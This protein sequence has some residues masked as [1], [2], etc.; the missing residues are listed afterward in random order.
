M[1]RTDYETKVM[2]ALSK[3]LFS[4]MDE[5][6]SENHA[7]INN[8]LIAALYGKSFIA[9]GCI[10]SIILDYE[11]NDYD[12]Y[13]VD[14][15]TSEMFMSYY[16][17]KNE[18]VEVR[19]KA[20]LLLKNRFQIIDLL[21]GL[22]NII[23][24]TFDFQ[25]CCAW[26]SFHTFKNEPTIES[27]LKGPYL[28]IPE[29]TWDAILNKKLIY[30]GSNYPLVALKR[31]DKFLKRGFTISNEELEKIC[32][33]IEKKYLP[34]TKCL[35]WIDPLPD[36]PKFNWSVDEINMIL[37][38]LDKPRQSEW[39]FTTGKSHIWDNDHFYGPEDFGG[40]DY[41]LNPPDKILPMTNDEISKA[42]GIST[43]KM[44]SIDAK[45]DLK[46]SDKFISMIITI[47]EEARQTRL[48][49]TVSKIRGIY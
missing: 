1:K 7:I 26:F 47:L 29:A 21:H 37:D 27:L 45:T 3:K 43:H 2:T 40:E 15:I 14:K 11:V 32:M 16:A 10:S 28:E 24:P 18:L 23:V 25:H 34:K 17:D 48:F 35:K 19:T 4:F 30:N 39:P 38:S 20:A 12:L 8:P 42:F 33:D 49:N 13:F 6:G 36:A 9:G 31:V 5:F 41:P 46:H 44:M 22:P